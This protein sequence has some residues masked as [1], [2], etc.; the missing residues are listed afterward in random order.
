MNIPRCGYRRS[1][2]FL[3][4]IL[5]QNVKAQKRIVG[6]NQAVQGEFPFFVDINGCGA[7]LIAPDIVLTAAH[8]SEDISML[9][10]YV[11]VGAYVMGG[12]TGAGA[13]K[14]LVADSISHPQFDYDTINYDFALLRL[15]EKVKLPTSSNVVFKINKDENLPAVGQNLTV[16]GLGLTRTDD[17][18]LPNLRPNILQEVVVQATD[19]ETCNK[20]YYGNVVEESMLCAGV[21]GGGKSWIQ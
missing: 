14:V 18:D 1:M 17:V 8:C 19:H 2:A 6:G 9:G 10:T 16:I 13:A 5:L 4:L 3:S 20:Q 11:T 15:E 12:G 21:K 7:S